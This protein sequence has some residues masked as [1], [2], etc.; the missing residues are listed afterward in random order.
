MHNYK[1]ERIP[2]Y[3]EYDT[4]TSLCLFHDLIHSHIDITVIHCSLDYQSILYKYYKWFKTRQRKYYVELIC[5]T[6]LQPL[7]RDPTGFMLN[8]ENVV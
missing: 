8:H 6:K 5:T 2:K 7:N 3:L 1:I 4:S